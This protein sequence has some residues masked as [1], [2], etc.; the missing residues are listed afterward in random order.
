M[1]AL[2]L[3]LALSAPAAASP[4]PQAGTAAGSFLKLGVG[5]RA[6]AMGGACSA[7]CDDAYSLYWNPAGLS[8]V[9]A[10]QAAFQHSAPYGLLTHDFAAVAWRVEELDGAAAAG[11]T[12]LGARQSGYDAS[13]RPTGSFSTEDLAVSLAA[14]R[15][16]ELRPEALYEDMRVLRAGAAVKLLY[17]G[18]PG[19]RSAGLAADLGLQTSPY[20][21]PRDAVG[22]GLSLLNLGPGLGPAGA[23]SPLPSAAVLGVSYERRP[24]GLL[25]TA[26]LVRALDA[27]F[28][29]RF[30][31]EWRPLP[32]AAL[33]AG[34]ATLQAPSGPLDALTMGGALRL[35]TLTFGASLLNRSDLGRTM[36]LD[37]SWRW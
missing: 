7:V 18:A 35:G 13:D 4:A 31:L 5:A 32:V 15:R 24:A 30:G 22:L 1:K 17:Q 20:S 6:T 27:R 8:R 2:L 16:L 36:L 23:A 3:A 19:R 10:A 9:G 33:R 26:E 25:L 29:M 28:D 11:V 21:D 14:A 34:L 12:R 37:A